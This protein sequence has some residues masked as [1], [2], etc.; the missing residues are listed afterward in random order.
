MD[1]KGLA[2]YAEGVFAATTGLIKM[3]PEDKLDWKPD[4]ENNWMTVGQLLEH[5]HTSTGFCMQ[6]F[7]KD[8]WPIM[9]EEEMM[10]SAEKLPT[11]SSI[12]E[13]LEKMEGDRQL[14]AQILADLSEED[15]QNRLVTAPWNPQEKPLWQQLLYMVEHQVNH[16]ATLFAY[17]K[18]M[19]VKVN[20]LNL[21]G[22]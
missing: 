5:L 3:I 17:L 11:V 10:P 14:T 8:E 4:L 22:M 9:S 12:A 15:Y 6:C 18:H 2:E 16:K 13:A 20:T 21:Y 19:G 7:I 1:T